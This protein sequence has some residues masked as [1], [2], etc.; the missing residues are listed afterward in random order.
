WRMRR[1]CCDVCEPRRPASTY[2]SASPGG[3]A[4]SSST[5]GSVG[6]DRPHFAEVT[7]ARRRRLFLLQRTP[8]RTRVSQRVRDPSRQKQVDTASSFQKM[9]TCLMG[10]I[11]WCS[12][13]SQLVLWCFVKKEWNFPSGSKSFGRFSSQWSAG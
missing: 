7:D 13:I 8:D 9:A 10:S 3:A 6:F 5:F 1:A 12:S 4:G 2:H 11:K